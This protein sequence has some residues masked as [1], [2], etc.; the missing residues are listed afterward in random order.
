MIALSELGAAVEVLMR[1]SSLAKTG[2]ISTAAL[3]LGGSV[4]VASAWKIVATPTP[5]GAKSVQ[6]AGISCISVT[7]CIAVGFYT[8]SSGVTVTLAERWNGS[9]WLIQP[10][11]SPAG[12]KSSSLS[13][14]S[15]PSTTACTAVGRY[16]NSSG[17]SFELAERWNGITWTTFSIPNLAGA[18]SSLFRGISCSSPTSCVAVGSY[19]AGG[20]QLPLLAQSPAW[21]PQKIPAPTGSKGA[22][23]R[24]VSCLRATAICEMVGDNADSAGATVTLAEEWNGKSATI[25]PTANPVGG[26][27]IVL[28]GV[29]CASS[30]VCFAVGS[31]YQNY[32]GSKILERFNHINRSWATQPAPS[33]PGA[34]NLV[35][36]GVSCASAT[37]CIAVGSYYN[38]SFVQL[39]FVEAWNGSTWAIQS[40]AIPTGSQGSELDADTDFLSSVS[41]PHGAIVGY[42]VNG[43]FFHALVEHN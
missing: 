42:S 31:Y 39:P 6:L 8:N 30:S 16:T 12:A 13:G 1:V 21:A 28:R 34:T 32:V 9:T 4:L 35:L 25:E 22:E 17:A 36:N 18:T 29:S 11:P 14:V 33:P 27:S 23:L 40:A 41:V 26:V 43:A 37:S 3:V 19:V 38:A 5:K 20:V 7:T 2:A 10:T 24:A 15:C